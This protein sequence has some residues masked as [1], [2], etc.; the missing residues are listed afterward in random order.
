MKLDSNASHVP[1]MRLLYPVEGVSM[2]VDMNDPVYI[3]QE[4]NA[5][6]FGG[7]EDHRWQV[8]FMPAGDHVTAF[9]T[10]LGL[11]KGY[12][13][14][15]GDMS[16]PTPP[17]HQP[18]MLEHTVAECLDMAEQGRNDGTAAQMLHEQTNESD[19]ISRYWQVMEE[20]R[21]LVRNRSTFGPGGAIQRNGYSNEAARLQKERLEEAGV[22]PQHGYY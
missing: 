19:I 12:R 10:D 20:D 1:H 15:V 16:Y 13:I 4:G 2:R 18:I 5:L 21:R 7:T 22:N 11:A 9:Y 14:Q 3:I 6:G 8:L 17:F